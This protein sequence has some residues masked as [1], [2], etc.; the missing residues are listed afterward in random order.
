M[1]DVSGNNSILLKEKASL[2]RFGSTS[3]SPQVEEDSYL[4]GGPFFDVVLTEAQLQRSSALMLP[5]H[6]AEL[7]PR[8]TVP[9]TLTYNGKEW[10][11]SYRGESSRHPRFDSRWKVF[12][13]DNDLKCGDACV[14]ELLENSKENLRFKVIILRCDLPPELVEMVDSRGKSFDSPIFLE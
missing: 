13:R 10:N 11:S 9:V 12:A 7:L 6:I 2:E 5:G 14:F 8:A 3:E 1:A 4:Q